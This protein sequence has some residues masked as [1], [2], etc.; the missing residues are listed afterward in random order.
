VRRAAD[1][2]SIAGYCIG[3][4][5]CRV[6]LLAF[7]M[8]RT[9][10]LSRLLA[11]GRSRRNP[12][13]DPQSVVRAVAIAAAFLPLRARCLEQSL[14]AYVVLRRRG[15]DSH[16]RL[17]VQPYGFT[18]HAWVEVSGQPINERGELIRKLAIFGEPLL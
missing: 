3:L 6:A 15:I 7:G 16:V 4:V 13:V 5:C 2:L 1:G 12:N 8:N 11:T 9:M 18:A 14:V 17:G 10:A